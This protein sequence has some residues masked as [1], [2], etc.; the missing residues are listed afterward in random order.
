MAC[1]KI[2]IHDPTETGGLEPP[3]KWWPA[4]APKN[5]IKKLI[6]VLIQKCH[7]HIGG[8]R[9]LRAGLQPW[10]IWRK[11]GVKSSGSDI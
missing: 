5:S 6:F 1:K 11:T 2:Y 7:I 8:W 10:D 9:G 3:Q 4:G